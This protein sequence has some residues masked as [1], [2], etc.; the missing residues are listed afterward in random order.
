[1]ILR[2]EPKWTF[3]ESKIKDQHEAKNANIV[4]LL[5]TLID[6]QRGKPR[7]KKTRARKHGRCDVDGDPV[8]EEVKKMREVWEETKR[9]KIICNDKFHELEK[10]KLELE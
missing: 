8:V 2:H 7:R 4:M 5:S 6:H 3:R 1:M 10:S 9:D